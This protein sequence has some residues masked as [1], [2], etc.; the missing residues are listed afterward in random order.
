[1]NCFN[2]GAKMKEQAVVADAVWGETVINAISRA[3][4]CRCGNRLYSYDEATKLQE[5]A[6]G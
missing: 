6:R 3:W 5:I 4:V 1:M 2:C